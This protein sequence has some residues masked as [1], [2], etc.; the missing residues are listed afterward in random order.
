MKTGI[1]VEIKN[2]I[3]IVLQPDGIFT[4]LTTQPGWTVG[5]VVV[6]KNT[7][8]QNRYLRY[9]AAAACFVLFVATAFF[10]NNLYLKT[11]AVISLDINPSFEIELNRQGKVTKA[12]AYNDDGTDLLSGLDLK[13]K[14]YNE[15]LSEILQNEKMRVYLKDNENLE[16]AVY[17]S[18][19]KNNILGEVQ[20]VIADETTQYKRV[21]V[22]CSSVSKDILEEAHSRKMT[23]GKWS[24]IKELQALDPTIDVEEY[25]H[26]DVGAI[27]KRIRQ[28]HNNSSQEKKGHSGKHNGNSG[29]NGTKKQNGKH[30]S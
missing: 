9:L 20:K 7:V 16:V 2:E 24:A 25:C 10:A 17:S 1:V 12:V 22:K 13:W 21:K 15:A 26:Y 28:H 3:A 29:E 8:K 11:D 19:S 30:N 27:R 18:S 4:E 5:S 14:T 23:A 6:L